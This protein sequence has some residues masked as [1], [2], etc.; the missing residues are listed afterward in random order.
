MPEAHEPP[1]LDELRGSISN[2]TGGRST[3][4]FIRVMRSDGYDD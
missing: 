4:E 2:L 1:T 3:E